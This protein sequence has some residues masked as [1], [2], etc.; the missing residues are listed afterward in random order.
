MLELGRQE[1]LLQ[2]NKSSEEH[3]RWWQL[4]CRKRAGNK[5]VSSRQVKKQDMINL[6]NKALVHVKRQELSKKKR[7]SLALLSERSQPKK[8]MYCILQWLFCKLKTV[9]TV[10]TSILAQDPRQ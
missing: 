9:K 3:A 10:E 4:P 5:D 6:E 2:I 7:E 1:T 8:D